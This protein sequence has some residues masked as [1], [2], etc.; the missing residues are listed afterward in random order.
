MVLPPR[1]SLL[2]SLLLLIIML[3][4][5]FSQDLWAMAKKPPADDLIEEGQAPIQ[6]SPQPVINL[7]DSFGFALKRSDELAIKNV[8]IEKNWA[9]F[10]KATG[11]AIGDVDF[12][13]TD[14]FQ[15]KTDS[16]SSSSGYNTTF[17]KPET[18]ERSFTVNQPLFQ[19]FK[20]IA[21]LTAVG[22]ISKQRTSDRD[23]AEQLLFLDVVT[24]YNAIL[25]SSH[26]ILI[27]TEIRDLL[28]DRIKELTEWEKIGR[29]R[30]SEIANAETNL[31]SAE[32]N[33]ARSRGE[34]NI[35]LRF[36]EFL[37][38]IPLM[39]RE[40]EDIKSEVSAPDPVQ[41]FLKYAVTRPDVESARQAVKTA[42]QAIILSQ[43]GLWPSI[44]LNSNVYDRR[45]GIQSPILWDT[46]FT[47]EVPLSRGGSTLGGIKEAYSNW[48]QAKLN[49]SKKI[50]EA[51][52]E[53]KRAYEAWV[54]SYEQYKALD[55]AVKAAERNYTL[56]KA[57]YAHNLVSNLEVLQALELLNNTQLAFNHA[58]YDLLT[59]YWNLQ[60]ATGACCKSV[61]DL[62]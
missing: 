1:I 9:D 15:E 33:L 41:T 56:Q 58:Y 57:D 21:A 31:R 11:V 45:E 49:L 13:M 51:V 6:T 25:R 14:F 7:S 5:I 27:I 17:T 19:G 53:I 62:H 32:A 60:V 18:R 3:A 23:R 39:N 28:K 10:L 37:T 26:D 38:G 20:S 30:N 22:S 52:F 47:I 46:L 55:L 61:K 8:E 36:L 54:S 40:L 48:K 43:S 4:I 42:F 44:S 35:Q 50:R 59:E 34:R 24:A 2:P 29:S 16:T 12:T